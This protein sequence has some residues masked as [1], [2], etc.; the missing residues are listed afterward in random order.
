MIQLRLHGIN[1]LA[2]FLSLC[3]TST[4]PGQTQES[5]T[6]PPRSSWTI[7]VH[8]GAG[9]DPAKWSEETKTKRKEGI[10]EALK[11]GA[12]ALAAGEH[13]IDVVEKVVRVLE[14]NPVFNAGRGAVLNAN[15]TAEL[16]ASIMDG[17]TLRCGAIAG[18]TTVKNPISL[19]RQVM[20]KTPHV[21]LMGPGADNFAA[22]QKLELVDPSYFRLTP[23]ESKISIYRD[24]PIDALGTVGCVIVDRYGDVAA[25]TSTGGLSKKMP[26]RVGDSPIIGAGT[27]AHNATCAI[28]GTGVG[29]EFIRN[30]I[31]FDVAAQMKYQQKSLKEAVASAIHETL[32]K[33]VGGVIAVDSDGNVAMDHNTPGMTCGVANDRGQFEVYL[34]V[35][36]RP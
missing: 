2:F 5:A 32:A 13:A 27:Y 31:G 17:R 22:E 8:G 20:E 28:S 10:T 23:Q 24:K 33:N 16:D 11:R 25:A 21:L 9:G 1:I 34:E 15:D 19:A 18:V 12:D 35:K 4:C 26:G 6:T 7:A 36:R 3:L 29:E 14:D 30:A